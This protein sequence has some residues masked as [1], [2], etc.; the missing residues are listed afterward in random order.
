MKTIRTAIWRRSAIHNNTE[1]YNKTD[2]LSATRIRRVQGRPRHTVPQ[3][4]TSVLSLVNCES[5]VNI[6][7]QQQRSEKLI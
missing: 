3:C 5:V 7:K 4:S 1:E 2:G 6:Q